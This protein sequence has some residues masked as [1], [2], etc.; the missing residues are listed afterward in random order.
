MTQSL[1]K[2]ILAT[3]KRMHTVEVNFILV[4]YTERLCI[5]MCPPLYE[6]LFPENIVFGRFYNLK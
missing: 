6:T 2:Q 3:C 5:N 4:C 1:R